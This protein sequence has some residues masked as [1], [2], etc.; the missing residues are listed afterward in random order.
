VFFHGSLPDLMNP[1]PTRQAG[2]AAGEI[3]RDREN[4]SEA[5]NPKNFQR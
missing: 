4:R 1:A 5:E 3:W 2:K